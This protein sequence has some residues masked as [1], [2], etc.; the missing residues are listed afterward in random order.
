MAGNS[1]LVCPAGSRRAAQL[2]TTIKPSLA[3]T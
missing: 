3:K 2:A 1:G